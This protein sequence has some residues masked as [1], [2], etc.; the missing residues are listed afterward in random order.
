M[1]TFEQ[2]VELWAATP[3]APAGQGT[4]RG[5]CLRLGGGRHERPERAE[6]TPE[7][8]VVGDRWR[9]SDD[10]E[11]LCQVT[12]M[13]AAVAERIAHPG[14]PGDEAGDNLIVDLDLSE[15]ALPV[16]VR[17]HVG[18]ALL[19][20]TGEPHLGCQKFKARFGPGALRWVNH[21]EHREQ[22]LRG[23]NLRVLEAGQVRVGDRVEVVRG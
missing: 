8:G 6:L 11:R 10:P 12:I 7:Q 21:Q 9:L 20:V 22:R 14:T 13:N 5:I 2:L 3:R 19:E 16:G 4:V 1:K 18:S 23:A 17:L 15:A